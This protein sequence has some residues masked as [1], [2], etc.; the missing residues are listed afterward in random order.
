MPIA[1]HI[2]C[3]FA[4][5]FLFFLVYGRRRCFHGVCASVARHENG[6]GWLEGGVDA[7]VPATLKLGEAGSKDC[8]G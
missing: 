2:L 1:V 4:N 5:H 7:E 8:P 3:G 6:G